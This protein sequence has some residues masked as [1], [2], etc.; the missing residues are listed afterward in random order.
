MPKVLEK[1]GYKFFF[2]LNEGNPLEPVH[3]HIRKDGNLSKFWLEPDVSLCKNYGL[4]A[5]ELNW[6]FEQV[7]A[8]SD[9]I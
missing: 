7:E 5:K 3:I 4:S 6:I 2:F 8:N 9:K 1:N